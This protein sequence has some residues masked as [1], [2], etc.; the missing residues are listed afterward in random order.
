MNYKKHQRRI[1]MN[2]KKIIPLSLAALSIAGALNACSDS[3]VVGADVQDNSM[4]QRSSSSVEPG[5]SSLSV[6]PESSSSSD[7]GISIDEP[8]KMVL[9]RLAQ[10]ESNAP[11]SVVNY[12]TGAIEESINV[13][14]SFNSFVDSVLS[15]NVYKKR[16]P[17]SALQQRKSFAG[18]MRDA[19]HVLH[20]P[21]DFT[22][23]DD[24]KK[25]YCLL[26]RSEQYGPYS[27]YEYF[28][29]RVYLYTNEFRATKSLKVYDS[30]LVE[31]FK[32]DCATENGSYAVVPSSTITVTDDDGVETTYKNYAV[33]CQL[34]VPSTDSLYIDSYWWN[35][36][37]SVIIDGCAAPYDSVKIDDLNWSV[38]WM[39]PQNP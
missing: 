12:G 21:V 22:G 6:K 25:I 38:S 11:V 10:Y 33:Q 9:A 29:M 18:V 17:S 39:M 36:Y 27:Q 35:K 23:F 16:N 4:A 20:G 30:T 32:E 24:M 5:S 13:Q 31:Q 1:P 37:A 15:Q 19:N 26:D 14:E 28:E 34:T 7:N 2:I 8:S 3:T